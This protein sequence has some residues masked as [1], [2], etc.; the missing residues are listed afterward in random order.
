VA[1]L[2]GSDETK[3][4]ASAIAILPRIFAH[5]FLARFARIGFS[6]GCCYG[7]VTLKSETSHV[8][9]VLVELPA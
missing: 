2:A 9:A 3:P 8:T 7:L 5:F 4:S 1:D 6:R